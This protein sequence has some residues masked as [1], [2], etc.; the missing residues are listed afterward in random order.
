MPSSILIIDDQESLRHFLERA[1]ADAGHDVR[2]AGT[3]QD[4]LRLFHEQ[5]PDIVLTDLKLPDISGIELLTRFKSE[6]PE[7]PVIL[8]TAFGEIRNAVEAMKQGAY[9]YL[10]KPVNLEQVTLVVDKALESA[11]MWRE[12][13]HHRR[14]E[15]ERFFREFVRG[16]A[17]SILQVYDT[18][19][20]VAGSETTTVLITGESGTGK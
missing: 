5:A 13:E 17:P 15:R 9:D 4:A 19:E 18:V 6:T 16:T 7:M 11:R 12:L 1:M 3:G 10:T 8:M 14:Q 2:S 20:K